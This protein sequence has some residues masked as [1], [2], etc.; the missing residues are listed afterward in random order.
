MTR[1]QVA[2]KAQALRLGT[3]PVA[4]RIPFSSVDQVVRVLEKNPAFGNSHGY[5]EPGLRYPRL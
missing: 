3:P 5:G 2:G 1:E 4:L